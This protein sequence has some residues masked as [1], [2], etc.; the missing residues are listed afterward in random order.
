MTTTL[1]ITLTTAAACAL[2]AVWLGMRIS[3][4][5]RAGRVSIGDG[6]DERLA[7]RMR[8]Q[9][10]FAEYVPVMLI[11]IGLI[12]LAQGTSLALWV[13]AALLLL[14]RVLHPIGMDGW[15]PGRVAGAALTYLLLLG[16][17]GWAVAIPY[18]TLRAPTVLQIVN[19]A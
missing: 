13:A 4:M 12:E 1:P 16:L 11:L 5:R 15:M 6:G 8:A 7:A 18:L 9:L 17:A 19:A 2:I 3:R 14:A 10:N